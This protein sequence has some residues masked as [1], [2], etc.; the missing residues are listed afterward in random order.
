MDLTPV[1]DSEVKKL[2]EICHACKETSHYSIIDCYRCTAF[3]HLLDRENSEHT[4]T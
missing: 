3:A 4:E 2:L 1:D